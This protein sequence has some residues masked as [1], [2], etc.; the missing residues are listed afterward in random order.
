MNTEATLQRGHLMESS[1]IPQQE[2]DRLLGGSPHSTPSYTGR[3]IAGYEVGELLGK[4]GCGQ[5][6]SGRHRWLDKAVAIKFLTL[7]DS[8]PA[9]AMERFRR[10]A[11]TAASLN[12]AGF[13]RATDGGVV[14]GTA[15]IVSDLI[16]GETLSELVRRHGAL[17]VHIASE[18]VTSI[19][20]AFSYLEQ[21][22]IVHRDLKPSNVMVDRH[23]RVYV[24]DLGL[25]RD[26]DESLALTRT[27][28]FMGT[29]DYLAPEQAY[30]P[31]SAT[32]KSDMYSLGCTLYFL[33]TGE[34]PHSDCDGDSLAARLKAH[35]EHDPAPVESFRSD[36]PG[37]V[38]RL[39]DAML[40]KSPADR[41][42]SFEAI[43]A[44]L[45]TGKPQ[46]DIVQ[47]LAG[48]P[49]TTTSNQ[50][51]YDWVD[52]MIVN[53]WQYVSRLFLLVFGFIET[54]PST[55]PGAPRRYR[56][57]YRW[58]KYLGMI[59]GV[60]LFLWAIGIGIQI[61][62]TDFFVGASPPPSHQW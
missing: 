56:R 32:S 3:N 41:P 2:L 52:Q 13:V 17:P 40:A 58:A 21:R 53:V 1:P 25:A 29:V 48:G 44:K 4:G 5:V 37:D 24:L 26:D 9:D 8:D 49:A 60:H 43:A 12:H 34:A 22:Q 45:R 28:A 15:F 35:A 30:D 23:G 50:Q 10:E 47:M 11:R 20:E 61:P 54:A 39:L 59:F 36:V 18:I 55:R 7:P 57:S 16:E 31:R 33:L 6:Y 19:A 62:G 14:D 51:E 27:G 46:T 38:L 42:K